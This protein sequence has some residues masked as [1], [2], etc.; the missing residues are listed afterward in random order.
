MRSRL[1][2]VKNFF[3]VLKHMHSN[4]QDEYPFWYLFKDEFRDLDFLIDD[5]ERISTICHSGT[6]ERK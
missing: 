6:V 1:E 4:G 5:Y 2:S 3:D